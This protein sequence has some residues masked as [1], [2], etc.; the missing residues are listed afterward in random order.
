[1]WGDIVLQMSIIERRLHGVHM[2]RRRES[3]GGVT[4][5]LLL[6]PA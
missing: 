6:V 5:Q 4:G 1:V 2:A 3:V